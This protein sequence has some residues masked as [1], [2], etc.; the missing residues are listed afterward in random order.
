MTW[1]IS[2]LDNKDPA[3]SY[4]M[5]ADRIGKKIS[6]GGVKVIGTGKDGIDE[7][8]SLAEHGFTKKMS[9]STRKKN[10]PFD[11]MGG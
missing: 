6:K 11:K 3:K 7:L 10:D 2:K 9:K 1:G 4:E 5:N 8:E